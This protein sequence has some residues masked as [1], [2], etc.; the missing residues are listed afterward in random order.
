MPHV[1]RDVKSIIQDMTGMDIGEISLDMDYRHDLQFGDDDF[2][3]LWRECRDLLAQ[4][5]RIPV[6]AVR[7]WVTIHDTI[8]SV[9]KAM[10]DRRIHKV[11]SGESSGRHL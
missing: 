8:D 2:A 5:E 1:I 11:P 10:H 3:Y 6:G 7:S 4:N 9:V